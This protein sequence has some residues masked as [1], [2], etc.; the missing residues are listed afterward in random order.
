[1]TRSR[2]QFVKLDTN[3]INAVVSNLWRRGQQEAMVFGLQ[4]TDKIRDYAMDRLGDKYAHA[5]VVNG[6]VICIFGAYPF[7]GNIYR[8]WFLSS[9]DFTDHFVPITRKLKR[10]MDEGAAEESAEAI[11][12]YSACVH[13]L[14]GKWF[15]LLGLT[16]DPDYTAINGVTRFIKVY[17]VS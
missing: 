5:A 14:A 1:M 10:M 13:P 2:L 11:E 6:H 12:T 8:T 17:E 9:E 16:P 7:N 3:H 15:G 4:D